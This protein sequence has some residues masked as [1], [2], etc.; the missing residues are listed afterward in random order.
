MPQSRATALEARTQTDELTGGP[1]IGNCEFHD[2]SVSSAAAL[3]GSSHHIGERG[4]QD[5]SSCKSSLQN[6]WVHYCDPGGR[7]KW[8]HCIDTEDCFFEGPKGE[9]SDNLAKHNRDPN[10]PDYLAEYRSR[11]NTKEWFYTRVE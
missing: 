3:A 6:N 9:C 11:R 10:R 2:L 7:G 8:W 5:N 4:E 1:D